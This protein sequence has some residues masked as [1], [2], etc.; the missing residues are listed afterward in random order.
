MRNYWYAFKAL[1]HFVYLK[2]YTPNFSFSKSN[3]IFPYCYFEFARNAKIVFGKQISMRRNNHVTVRKNGLL[4]IHDDCFFNSNC[5]ITCHSKIIIG[6]N[7]K[8]GPSCMI[9]DQDHNMKDS[10]TIVEKGN[11][12]TEGIEIGQGCWFG[13]GCIILKGTHIGD[14]CVFAAGT[15]VKGNFDSNSVV[16]QK[17]SSTIRHIK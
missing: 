15:I 13:A 7:C 16:I 4:E 11:F 3:L 14:H 9:F 1:L 17:R 2:I 6:Q 10:I 5:V 8:F 12:T